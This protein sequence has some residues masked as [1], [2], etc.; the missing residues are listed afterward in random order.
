MKLLFFYQWLAGK[1]SDFTR[2][3]QENEALYNQARSFWNKLEG[4]SIILVISFIVLGTAWAAIYYK[5]FN[6][7]PGRHYKPKWW[8]IFMLITFVVTLVVTFLVEYFAVSPKLSGAAMLEFK[9]ALANSIYAVG[10]Y[11]LASLVWC[12][13]GLPT[14]AYK[15]LSFKRS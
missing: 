10:M 8:W 7:K 9:I 11:I 1:M 12:N 5:P 13:F 14:N 2:P 15:L 6:D 3:F 4:I